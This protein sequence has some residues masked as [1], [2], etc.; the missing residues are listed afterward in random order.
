MP[1]ELTDA[2]VRLIRKSARPVPVK[3]VAQQGGRS[4]FERI[5]AGG[6]YDARRLFP[7]GGLTT[8]YEQVVAY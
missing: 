2:E 7:P 1:P 4:G 6:V 5:R 8:L 3:A